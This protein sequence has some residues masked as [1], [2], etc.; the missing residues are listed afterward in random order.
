MDRVE[1]DERLKNMV[2]KHLGAKREQEA[3]QEA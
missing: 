3:Q 2:E 1:H